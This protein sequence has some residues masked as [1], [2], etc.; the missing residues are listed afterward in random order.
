[1]DR[2]S[3]CV[4]TQ[5][6]AYLLSARLE[7]SRSPGPAQGQPRACLGQPA[8]SSRH[9][10]WGRMG[11]GSSQSTGESNEEEGRGP[12]VAAKDSRQSDCGELG[13]PG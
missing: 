2:Y 1:M 10:D 3:W 6:R 13:S 5:R 8:A 7:Q 4:P 9:I 11:G 12:K